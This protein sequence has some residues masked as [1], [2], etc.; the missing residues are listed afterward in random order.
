[1]FGIRVDFASVVQADGPLPDGV[2]I[3]DVERGSP[4]DVKYKE[5]FERS[6]WIVT[7]VNGKPVS[8]AA[9]FYRLAAAVK[10][11]LELKII[12][13]VRTPEISTRTITLP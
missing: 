6:R 3:R 2:Y 10:G 8:A 5:L 12:E 11:P 7:S 4:A 13:V 1:M 9:D